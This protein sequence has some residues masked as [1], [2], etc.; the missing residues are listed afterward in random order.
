MST[1]V[2]GSATVVQTERDVPPTATDAPKKAVARRSKTAT[3]TTTTTNATTAA[4]KQ[5]E[6]KTSPH[7]TYNDMIKAAII[8]LKEKKGSSRA[9]ILKYI[10]QTYKLGDNLS[11][12]N[13]RLRVAL[14]RATA[15]GILLQT[16]GTG[17]AGSFRLA[18][19]KKPAVKKPKKSTPAKP[20]TA[21]SATK[22][23]VSKSTRKATGASKTAMSPKK[24]KA[25]TPKKMA[26]PAKSSPKKIPTKKVPRPKKSTT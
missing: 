11:M 19:G 8:E 5:K 22:Q 24:K 25:A 23:T 15:S 13:A 3:T 9:A 2:S 6:R 7:P 1:E 12:I 14:K 21:K 26:K 4:A 10:L 18:E 16:K 20:T 17:A